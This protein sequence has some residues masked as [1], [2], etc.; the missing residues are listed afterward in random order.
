MKYIRL[1]LLVS[2]SIFCS[3]Q[4]RAQEQ[5][6][7]QKGQWMLGQSFYLN[8]SSTE[9]THFAPEVDYLNI[10]LQSSVLYFVSPKLSVGLLL[11]YEY[12]Q[13]NEQY[14]SA[15]FNWKNFEIGPIFRYYAVAGLF[16]EAA[17]ILNVDYYDYVITEKGYNFQQQVG[18]GYSYL[19]TS[20]VAL[21]PK[22]IH[23]FF[24]TPDLYN[25]NSR[26]MFLF[27]FQI[28]F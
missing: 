28:K 20:R 13:R 11:N 10:Q 26:T 24:A 16:L 6:S 22:F 25:T 3:M 14:Q 8:S 7:I 27:G 1:I 18:V 19:I 4:T 5:K 17:S 12:N 9:S 21:E 15:P 23:Q 2:I